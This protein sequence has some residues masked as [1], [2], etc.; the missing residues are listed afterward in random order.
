M[1]SDGVKI[2]QVTNPSQIAMHLL[3]EADPS[4]TLVMGYLAGGEIFNA[5]FNGAVVGT[6][7]LT[8]PEPRVKEIK[9]IAV[10]QSHRGRG[11]GTQLLQHAIGQA[12]KAGATSVR[13]C[14]GNSSIQQLHLY[15]KAGFRVS[16]VVPDF[17][18]D[19][20]PEPIWENGLHCRDL[21]VLTFSLEDI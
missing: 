17:F 7:V 6:Y 2:I 9:N 13:I 4:E 10:V 14:T 11:I 1:P 15:Q 3:L 20:Y 16:G 12:L 8:K 21:V 19:N 18:T 5:E